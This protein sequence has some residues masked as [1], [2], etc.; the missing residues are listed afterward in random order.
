MKEPLRFK[1][2]ICLGGWQMDI[3]GGGSRWIFV[4]VWVS[5]CCW[6]SIK[7]IRVKWMVTFFLVWRDG[8]EVIERGGLYWLA[9]EYDK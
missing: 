8:R 1:M 4:S 3:C 9:F 2:D 6:R 5:D 7:A